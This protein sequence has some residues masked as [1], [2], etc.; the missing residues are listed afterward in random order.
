M[1]VFVI[2]VIINQKKSHALVHPSN[3]DSIKAIMVILSQNPKTY[4]RR[5]ALFL[6]Y[7]ISYL[8]IPSVNGGQM[9]STSDKR[10]IFEYKSQRRDSL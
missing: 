6:I 2:L 10:A 9:Q 3:S 7:I 5:R 8:K 1:Q 4:F